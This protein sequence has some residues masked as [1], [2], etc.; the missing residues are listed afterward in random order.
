M[1]VVLTDG[2]IVLRCLTEQ[3]A[4]AHL[5]GEDGDQIRWLSGGPG[6]IERL[7]PWIHE[8]RCEWATGGPRRNFGIFD[9]LTAELIGN[10]EAHVHLEGMAEGEVNVSYGVFPGWRGKGI[11]R[12]AVLLICDWLSSDPRCT[13]AVIRIAPDNVPSHAVAESAGF[14]RTGMIV[15]A[16]GEELIR[17]ERR[18]RQTGR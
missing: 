3:D 13:K 11:A 14:A 6:S 16:N 15:A 7:V 1:F 10:S 17:Y 5:A 2:I 9:A 4:G 18:L 8:N 12:R